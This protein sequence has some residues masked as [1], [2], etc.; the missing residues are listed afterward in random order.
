MRR[1]QFQAA[2]I[3]FLFFFTIKRIWIAL[4]CCLF[5][6]ICSHIFWSQLKVN[7][8]WCFTAWKRFFILE[9][10]VGF[11]LVV[12][13][14]PLGRWTQ[15]R[16]RAW[17]ALFAPSLKYLQFL[18]IYNKV[19]TVKRNTNCNFMDFCEPYVLVIQTRKMIQTFA[20]FKFFE[21]CCHFFWVFPAS[22]ARE[23]PFR[24][25]NRVLFCF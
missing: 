1:H 15:I 24:L 23:S 4:M 7:L 11:G 9:V 17:S 3:A 14:G 10:N 6:K 8:E 22:A 13:L 21:N 20:I 12:W 5:L 25:D 2:V 16:I 19:T 18:F